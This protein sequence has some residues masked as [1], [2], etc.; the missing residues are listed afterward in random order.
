MNVVHETADEVLQSFA[1]DAKKKKNS[2]VFL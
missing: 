2:N 1:N